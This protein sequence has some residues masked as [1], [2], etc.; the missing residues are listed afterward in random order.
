[1][2]HHGIGAEARPMRKRPTSMGFSHKMGIF[3]EELAVDISPQKVVV[4]AGRF[5]SWALKHVTVEIHHATTLN[6][7]CE[8]IYTED[9][10]D[11]MSQD[12]EIQTL[13]FIIIAISYM[14]IHT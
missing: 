9:I 5:L 6:R 14:Y 1:M 2:D 3:P 7:G 11:F 12:Q 4:N 8:M 13:V 10:W